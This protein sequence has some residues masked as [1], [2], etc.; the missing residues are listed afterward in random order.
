MWVLEIEPGSFARTASTFNCWVSY[1]PRVHIFRTF[2]SRDMPEYV[3]KGLEN[4]FHYSTETKVWDPRFPLC[5]WL[6]S[7]FRG[8]ETKQFSGRSPWPFHTDQPNSLVAR[9][10]VDVHSSDCLISS[11]KSSNVLCSFVS[12]SSA[13]ALRSF[14]TFWSVIKNSLKRARYFFEWHKLKLQFTTLLF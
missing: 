6:S 3:C 14:L 4:T 7:P 12:C 1:L 2:K 9:S 8:D 5:S 10:Q 11:W 13:A